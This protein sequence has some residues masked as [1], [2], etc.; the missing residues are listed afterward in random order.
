LTLDTKHYNIAI[1][2]FQRSLTYGILFK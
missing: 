2:I 1:T